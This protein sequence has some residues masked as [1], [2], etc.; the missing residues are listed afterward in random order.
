MNFKRTMKISKSNSIVVIIG[1][2][3]VSVV[4]FGFV[5]KQSSTS[6]PF[7]FFGKESTVDLS[8]LNFIDLN[9]NTN[10]Q[11]QLGKA[12]KLK[13]HTL[14]NYKGRQIQINSAFDDLT[15][16]QALEL[17][18]PRF[19]NIAESVN[20]IPRIFC[21]PV[22]D[23]TGKDH[24]FI[25]QKGSLTFEV[26][27]F[28]LLK[29]KTIK[30]FTQTKSVSKQTIGYSEVALATF[31]ADFAKI[32]SQLPK[33]DAPYQS[34]QEFKIYGYLDFTIEGG[35]QVVRHT[36]DPDAITNE[37]RMTASNIKDK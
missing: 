24:K 17:S 1:I 18:E 19:G 30:T 12:C 15:N 2:A 35:N 11:Q 16:P 27:S 22:Q 26:W 28:D 4:I 9:L 23:L 29:D 31:E 21:Q 36:I 25:I 32:N 7:L 5:Q 34:R 13:Q 20:G 37:V 6:D 3:L 8:G 14:V 33:T 10:V